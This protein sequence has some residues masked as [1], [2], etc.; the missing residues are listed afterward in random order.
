[1]VGIMNNKGIIVKRGDCFDILMNFRDKKHSN[2]AL[3]DCAIKMSVKNPETN[4][5]L[6]SVN[7]EIISAAEGKA[8]IPLKAR[9]TNNPAQDY[10][11]DI[12]I[13]LKNG[14]VHTVYPQD[15][16]KPGIFRITEDVTEA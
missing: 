13:T 12:Q 8:R 5:L 9:H 3:D 1:M 11:C 2:F 15:I 10:V 16:T 7:A 4:K 14:D 6:F